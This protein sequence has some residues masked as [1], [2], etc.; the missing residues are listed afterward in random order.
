[1]TGSQNW[2]SGSLSKG[3][4]TTLNVDLKSAWSQ[5]MRNWNQIRNH[6]RRLPYNR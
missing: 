3:D 6:A 2:V 5:Y 4:E 1:M